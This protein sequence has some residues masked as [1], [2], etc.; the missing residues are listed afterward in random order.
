METLQR[1]EQHLERVATYEAVLNAV[2]RVVELVQQQHPNFRSLARFHDVTNGAP[3]EERRNAQPSDLELAI[4]AAAYF[5]TDDVLFDATRTLAAAIHAHVDKRSRGEQRAL[6]SLPR[7]SAELGSTQSRYGQNCV[8][9]LAAIETLP[10]LECGPSTCALCALPM[11]NR[12]RGDHAQ[13]TA[14]CREMCHVRCIGLW[15]ATAK[16]GGVSRCPLCLRSPGCYDVPCS[17]PQHSD[18][19]L[20][21]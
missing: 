20:G 3:D 11:R 8:R 19:E 4:T 7:L 17:P 13:S 2:A 12:R 9:L 10:S 6:D 14:C 16:R 15:N 1:M 5:P 18:D 21:F